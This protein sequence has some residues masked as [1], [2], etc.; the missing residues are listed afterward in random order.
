MANSHVAH[1]CII[2][3][4]V[5]LANGAL[6]AGHVTVQDRAFISGNCVIHQFCRIGTL[7]MLQG[8]AAVSQYAPPFTIVH[9]GLNRLCGLNVI[10]LR[11]AGFTAEQRLELK[12]LYH[13]LFRGGKNFRA[14][15]AEA[16]TQFTSPGAQ[17][18][19]DFVAASKRG[20]CADVG[21]KTESEDE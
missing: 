7:A 19:L 21:R 20:V 6:L 5:I 1:N 15:V 14:A 11:R 9:N 2:G 3:D 8:G 13:F 16:Q 12:Q 17:I 10:G 4:H 18:M